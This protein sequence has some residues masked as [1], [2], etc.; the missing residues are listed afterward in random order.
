[1]RKRVSV[2]SHSHWPWG[3]ALPVGGSQKSLRGGECKFASRE[4]RMVSVQESRTT[5]AAESVESWG[6]KSHLIRMLR[7]SL[8]C[9]L[10]SLLHLPC[11]FLSHVYPA[12]GSSLM[13]SLISGR[14]QTGTGLFFFL[15][16]LPA[17]SDGPLFSTFSQHPRQSLWPSLVSWTSYRYKDAFSDTLKSCLI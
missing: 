11:E 5:R 10:S 17:C 6:G 8:L 7:A 12:C 1:M 14:V 13:N 15:P 4:K 2:S 3:H 16:L 9:G